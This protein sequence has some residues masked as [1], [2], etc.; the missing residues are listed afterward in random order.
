VVVMSSSCGTGRPLHFV[1]LAV[2][3]GGGAM[4]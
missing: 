3:G 4:G 1:A 2:E